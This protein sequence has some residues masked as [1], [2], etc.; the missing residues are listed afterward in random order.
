MSA[1]LVRI[2]NLDLGRKF[3]GGKEAL[4]AKLDMELKRIQEA[5]ALLSTL[6]SAWACLLNVVH[7][8]ALLCHVHTN[9]C[10]R[11]ART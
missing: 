7:L 6:E 10:R 11:L 3:N 2:A 4:H 1:V 9:S 5:A 8:L